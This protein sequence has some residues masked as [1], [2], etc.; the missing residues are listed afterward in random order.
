MRTLRSPGTGKIFFVLE[1]AESAGPF[2][3][4]LLARFD[5]AGNVF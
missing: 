3:M 2:I 5:V 1:E 4:L